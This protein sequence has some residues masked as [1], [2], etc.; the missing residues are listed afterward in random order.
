MVHNFTAQWLKG[1]KNDA[2]DALSRHPVHDPQTS[3]M[4]A[5]LDIHDNPEMSFTE[6]RAIIN[7]HPESLRLQKLRKEA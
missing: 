2:L 5:E 7:T 4:L 3:E 6:I 1:C